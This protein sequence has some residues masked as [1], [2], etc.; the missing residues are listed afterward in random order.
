MPSKS[1]FRQ[2]GAKHFQL[3]HRSQRDPLINDPDASQHV[4]KEV[5]RGNDRKGKTCADLESLLDPKDI[6]RDARF[7][8][9]EAAIY[10]IY[11]D[12]TKYDYMQHLRT[13]G[14][15]EEGV[16][17]ILIEAPST[18][19]IKSKAKGKGQEDGRML[20]NDIPPEVL[21]SRHEMPR[22][23]ESQQAIP[24]SISG[25][26]PDMDPHL[27]QTL[28]ALEDDAFVDD[29]LE[30]DFFGELVTGG[31]RGE[32]EIDYEFDEDGLPADTER[33]QGDGGE[34][35]SW[36]AE[37][38]KFKKEQK[39]APRS[40]YDEE[41]DSDGGDT[42]GDLP[43]L[44]VVGGKQRRKGSSIASGY[45]MSSSSMYRTEAL[46]TLD[47][48]FDQL[49]LNEYG[50]DEAGEL[51]E[52]ALE[53]SDLSDGDEVPELITSRE[54][55]AAMVDDF[56]ENYELVGRKLKPV[57][58]GD[59]A[60]DKLDNLRRAMGQDG[61]V[62]I[63]AAE[64]DSDEGNDEE[65]FASYHANEKEGRWDCE[66]ILTTYTNLEN[67]PKIIRARTSK[68]VPKIGLDPRTGL[69]SVDTKPLEG[70][71]TSA[72]DKERLHVPKQ[73]VT[74]ARDESKEEKK[75]RKEAVKAERQ[76]KRLKHQSQ[77]LS[78]K[79]KDNRTKKL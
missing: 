77:A 9:G 41:L 66:T 49:M 38:A 60:A 55:F 56:V 34:T 13:A 21:P 76:A 3:V 57:L 78:Q 7:N 59:S 53:S 75:A 69:P 23:F 8:V 16:E 6:A 63:S 37:F 50:S 20:L 35:G 29:S 54:D 52:E 28:E 12:D 36:E 48:R 14:T 74:R 30:D 39:R 25:F 67:H 43:R 4:L 19:K 24:E 65:L 22:Q 33:D 72:D 31:E 27:R 73:T 32:E 44:R 68:P 61:T 62:R 40:D 18:R 46:L 70:S 5:V 10:G 47:E 26:Q 71:N 1:I 79:T 42:V 64:N 58:H 11:F 2:P 17:S 15:E 45:S 51:E